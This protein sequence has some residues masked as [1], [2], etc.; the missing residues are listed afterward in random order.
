MSTILDVHKFL[1]LNELPYRGDSDSG[2]CYPSEDELQTGTGQFIRLFEY[3]LKKDSKLAEIVKTIPK[4]ATYTSHDVQNEI[5][6]LMATLVKEQV[7]KNVNTADVPFFTLKVDGTRDQTGKE[8]LSIVIR[9]VAEGAPNEHLLAIETT[10]ELGAKALTDVI[11]ECLRT[12]GLDPQQTLCQ[13]YDGAAVMAGRHGGVQAEI[14]KQLGKSIPYIHCYN[15]KLH[16]VV[17]HAISEDDRM[18]QYFDIC[19]AL[20]NFTHNFTVSNLYQGTKL[21][22]LLGQRWDGHLKT[23]TA[24]LENYEALIQLLQDCTQSHLPTKVVI[25]STGLLSKVQDSQFR[26]VAKFIRCLLVTLKPANDILQSEAMDLLTAS[27]IV[28]SVLL[29][30]KSLRSDDNFEQLYAAEFENE[31]LDDTNTQLSKKRKISMPS[32][33]NDSVLTGK[34]VHRPQSSQTQ[35]RCLYNGVID[36]TISEIETRFSTENVILLK[37]MK[38]LT[39]FDDDFLQPSVLEPISLL[40]GVDC[41]ANKEEIMTARSFLMKKHSEGSFKGTLKEMTKFLHPYREAFPAVYSLFASS[42]T[43]G[44]SNSSC[45]SSFSTLARILT[46]YRRGMTQKR[47]ADIVLLAHEKELSSKI[48]TDTFL[49]RFNALKN[50]RLRLW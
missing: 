43:F 3:T 28:D 21:S 40:C 10:S 22:R 25:D 39:S 27:D 42:L 24:I 45:E 18:R 1:V 11:L 6:S 33:L 30:I 35:M 49:K 4:V 9:Y 36:R 48:D 32:G 29:S 19:D 5:I 17:N 7:V 47:K 23:T 37:S 50:R 31:A 16:L 15:H 26:F 14:Q 12:N 2:I 44:A 34:I 38:K 8:N 46:P 13:C 41:Q 20:Y